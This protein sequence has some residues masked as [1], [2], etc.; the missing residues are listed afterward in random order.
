MYRIYTSLSKMTSQRLS[1][2]F[3]SLHFSQTDIFA[4]SFSATGSCTFP[5]HFGIH[6]HKTF[7]LFIPSADKIRSFNIYTFSLRIT[8]SLKRILIDSFD[9]FSFVFLSF[10]SFNYA[11]KYL[12]KARST[13]V[14]IVTVFLLL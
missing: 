1:M 2:Q 11:C 8:N 5:V 6:I 13:I 10:D 3:M 14:I 9:N 12:S 7:V 4:P